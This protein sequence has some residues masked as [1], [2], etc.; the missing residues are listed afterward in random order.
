MTALMPA[1]IQL[2][3]IQGLTAR[4]EA[5]VDDS[6]DQRQIESVEL[7]LDVARQLLERADDLAARE[8]GFLDADQ[9][10]VV[11]SMVRW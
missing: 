6:R 1:T 9:Q 3:R 4:I 5:A 2:N 11:R 10:S 7:L 8:G